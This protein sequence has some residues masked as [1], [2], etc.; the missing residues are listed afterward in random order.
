[1]PVE[2]GMWRIDGD[3]PR[4]LAAATLPSEATLE[5]YLEK[6]PSLLG[7]RLLVIGRQVR[8]PFGK[9]I[10]LLAMDGEG[11]LHV[12]ELKRDRTPR[13]V[14][15]QVLDYGAWVSTLDRDT[16]IDL[17][18]RH[19]GEDVA[20]E[21]AF[22]DVFGTPP[23]DELNTALQLHDRGHGPRPRLGADRH[24]PAHLRCARQRGLLLLP[25]GRRASLPRPVL[26]RTGR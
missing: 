5:Q 24:L 15:A 2:M 10:D 11:N 17:A 7:E 21:A 13:D 20:F 25:G 1:M 6:D 9:I 16:L 12:L 23:P 18:N 26:A 4:R 3:T 8:T 14:V 22:E 19:L